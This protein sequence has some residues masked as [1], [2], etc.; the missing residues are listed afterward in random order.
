[1]PAATETEAMERGAW[2]AG[3]A[4]G[5]VAAVEVE[6]APGVA[7]AAGADPHALGLPNASRRHPGKSETRSSLPQ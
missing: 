5:A 2:A 3:V 4:A 6:F 7:A 1:M